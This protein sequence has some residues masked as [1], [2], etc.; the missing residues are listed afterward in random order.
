[1]RGKAREMSSCT[2]FFF[3]CNRRDRSPFRGCALLQEKGSRRGGRVAATLSLHPVV[4]FP[5]L[6]SFHD[7]L[8]AQ[9]FS[10]LGLL[11]TRKSRNREGPGSGEGEIDEETLFVRC[12]G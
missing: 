11:K 1:M 2:I 7:A 12:G 5:A 9:L 3:C 8:P 10:V 6:S 4:R